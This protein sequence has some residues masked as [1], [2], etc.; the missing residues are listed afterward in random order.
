[1]L[2]HNVDPGGAEQNR[3]RPDGIVSDESGLIM[4]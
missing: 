2:E 3:L 1:M 4:N